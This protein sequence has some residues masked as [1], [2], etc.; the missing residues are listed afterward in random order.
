LGQYMDSGNKI[1]LICFWDRNHILQLQNKI[2]RFE[3]IPT[4]QY[5][6]AG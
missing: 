6:L 2:A 4:Y 5:R 3:V 1:V